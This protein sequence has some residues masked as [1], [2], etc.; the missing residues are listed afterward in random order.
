MLHILD[1]YGSTA[2]VNIKIPGW[3]HPGSAETCRK[4]TVF[5]LCLLFSAWKFGLEELNVCAVPNVDVAWS[6]L[7]YAFPLCCLGI[8]WIILWWSVAPVITGI[9]FVFPFHMFCISLV[10]SLYFRIFLVSFLITFLSCEITT[11]SWIVMSDW[12]LGMALSVCHCWFHYIITFPPRLVS[13]DFGMCWYQCLLSNFTPITLHIL[14][15]SLSLLLLLL[16]LLLFILF[17]VLI[18]SCLWVIR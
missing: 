6:F 14:K 13:T 12:L 10:R 11:L 2:C 17:F 8:S 16:L 1:Q 5:W 4:E 7:F 9:I 18:Y 3:W 15:C